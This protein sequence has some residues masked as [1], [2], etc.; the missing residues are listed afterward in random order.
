M[1]IVGRASTLASRPS[2]RLISRRPAMIFGVRHNSRRHRIA[3]DISYD[4]LELI[5]IPY[6]MVV[7]LALPKL[8]SHASQNAVSLTGREAFYGL[9]NAACRDARC[10]QQMDVIGHDNPSAKLVHLQAVFP[11]AQRVD[12]E[13]SDLILSEPD[14]AIACTVEIPVYPD[15]CLP[16]GQAF[17][18]DVALARQGAVQ[19][20][21]E[22]ER[23]SVRLPVRETAAGEAHARECL[24]TDKILGKKAGSEAGWQTWRFAP[25]IS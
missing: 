3:L 20:P 21:G 19:P 6:P 25:Q 4:S 9:L 8:L 7:R 5:S 12:D 23:C 13:L 10:Q 14:G 16:A 11:K 22:E 24:H 18:C 15:E 2:C 1:Q 17:W